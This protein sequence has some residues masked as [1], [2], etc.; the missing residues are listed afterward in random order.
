MQFR[1]F[2]DMKIS[3]EMTIV[4]MIIDISTFFCNEKN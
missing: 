3:L 2:Y 4:T 1:Y